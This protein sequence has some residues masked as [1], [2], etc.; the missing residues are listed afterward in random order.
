MKKKR[1]KAKRRICKSSLVASPIVMQHG[2]VVW[3]KKDGTEKVLLDQ[4]NNIYPDADSLCG[5]GI[6]NTGVDDPLKFGCD[7]HDFAYINRRYLESQG[8]TRETIDKHFYDIMLLLAEDDL[9]LHDRA[10]NYYNLVRCFGWMFY[11]T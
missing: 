8:W 11:Y 6:F 9:E 1:P 10:Q 5:I 4:S 3:K 7:W 2:I